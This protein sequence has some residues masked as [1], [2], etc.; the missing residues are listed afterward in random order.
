MQFY[1]CV[2]NKT[3]HPI[4]YV[5]KSL[6]TSIYFA[7]TKMHMHINS[8]HSSSYIYSYTDCWTSVV[9]ENE[10]VNDDTLTQGWS[11]LQLTGG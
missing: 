6:K 11:D 1:C 7:C 2:S 8:T 3:Q 5:S 10:K 9:L 4:S